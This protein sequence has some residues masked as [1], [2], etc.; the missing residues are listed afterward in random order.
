MDLTFLNGA[1]LFAA[2]AALLPLLIHLISRRRVATVD[3]S[4]LR[5]LKE[6]ER[7][8]IR[9]VRLRQI[10]LLIIR[11]LIIL[12]AALALARPTLRGTLAGSGGGH[13]R[14]SVAI[15]VDDS[16]SMS[17]SREGG[18]LLSEAKRAAA[19]IAGLLDEGDQA[20]VV[21]AGQPARALLDDGTFSPDVLLEAVDEISVGAGATDYGAAVASARSLLESSRN[22]N[23]EL[24]ILGDMQRTGWLPAGAREGGRAG[25]LPR[26]PGGAEAARGETGA[27]EAGGAEP[28]GARDDAAG[29]TQA[30]VLPLSG[31][32]S[33]LG[34][35]S[36]TV[37]RRHGRA[38]GV[39]SVAARVVNHGTRG[40]EVLV[41][42]ILDGE[43]VGQA[44]LDVAPGGS[45]TA[46]FAVTV[47]ES[48]WHECRVE[49]P[50]D[51]LEI[52]NRRY[53]VIE[54]ARV[55][56]VLLVRPA[57]SE[58][59]DTEPDDADYVSRALDPAS[60]GE[61]FSLSTVRADALSRQEAGRF[62]TVV[63]A[64]VGRL[65]ASAARWLMRHVGA[66]GGVLIV[67]GD[68]TDVR[69]WNSELLSEIA[70]T[71]V[72]AP[73]DRRGGVRLAPS[74]QGHPLL[75]GLVFGERLIDDISV[76]RAFAVRARRA[77]TVLELPGV[78][79]ALLF[80]RP[81]GPN[82]ASAGGRRSGEVA[83][84]ATAVDPEWSDLPRSGFVV[85]LL[86]RLVER[87]SHSGSGPGE[88]VVGEDLV[89][90]LP[91]PPSGRVEVET[92]D[93][94]LVTAGLPSSRKAV[95]TVEGT[96]VPGI[97]RFLEGGSAVA[98]GAV[99]IDP[100]ESDL[101]PLDRAEIKERVSP[102]PVTFIDRGEPLDERVLQ[103]RYGREL[104]RAL[105]YVALVL[106]ALEMYLARPRFA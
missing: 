40:G 100:A 33:N 12:A 72:L 51:A 74:S 78:G 101:T 68:R 55:T 3:F 5:F 67:L 93:G 47:D 58:R 9:R 21:S 103:A 102:L 13:A 17:R 29:G 91:D 83:V 65:D 57:G 35:A 62:P 25:A 77:E 79:P 19:E 4:S 10:L 46:R 92:P 42:L 69:F 54:P 59:E 37:E 7:K 76:R 36:V 104:W 23:R 82:V 89:V 70:D 75:D 22:L 106:V 15:V 18:D 11:S 50:P 90:A 87:L 97:Y 66:G 48:S 52:D 49:L 24:Y 71:E 105:L 44:G 45:A 39:F 98:M 80:A 27:S 86:H 41:K 56:E 61:T 1:F 64:D 43:H 81:S 88:A 73:V 96:E 31:A 16:A 63:L 84:L 60:T 38:A 20:F 99:N 95:A 85:P 34:V 8:R 6:L 53:F 94:R 14:T 26:G 28:G 32:A 30:Y 2:L